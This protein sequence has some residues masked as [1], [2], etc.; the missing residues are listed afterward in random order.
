[1]KL[2][3]NQP[4]SQSRQYKNLGILT[5]AIA[6]ALT[7]VAEQAQAAQVVANGTSETASGTYDTGTTT[8]TAGYGIYTLNNG[9]VTSTGTVNIVTGGS[10][11]RGVYVGTGG[12][13]TLDH[14]TTITQTGTSSRG[15]EVS[16]TTSLFISNGALHINSTSS[17]SYG[18]Y[19]SQ[20]TA[21]MNGGGSI[22]SYYY[23]LYAANAANVT[24]KD[25]TIETIG[26][27]AAAYI[28]SGSTVDLTNV[29]LINTGSSNTVQLSGAGSKLIMNGGS[30]TTKL[31]TTAGAALAVEQGAEFDLTG[32]AINTSTDSGEGIAVST[33]AFG[34]IRDSS[35]TTSGGSDVVGDAGAGAVGVRA[36]NG[37]LATVINTDIITSGTGSDGIESRD[38]GSQVT[39]VGG[40]V[41][42][43]ADGTMGVSARTGGIVQIGNGTLVT[44]SGQD[45]HA[46]YSSTAG[47][48]IV[49]DNTSIVTTGSNAHA[50][51]AESGGQIQL[52]QSNGQLTSTQGNSLYAEGGQITVVLDGS[53]VQ[54]SGILID[55][56]ADASNQAG[57]VDLT[58]SNLTMGGDIQ[59]DATSVA[60]LNLRSAAWSGKATNGTAFDLDGGST[61]NMTASSDVASLNH[62]GV[63]RYA[64]PVGRNFNTL[65]VHNQYTGNNGTVVL[66]TELGAD[67]SPTDRLVVE[68]NTAGQT[69]LQVV[70]AN[71]AG[72]LTAADGIELVSVAGQ[73]DGSF[74]LGNRVVA[75][76]YEYSL[77]QGGVGA[78]SDNGNWYLRSTGQVRSETGVYLRNMA[79]A[80]TMFVH[81]LHDRL[82]EPQFTDKYREGEQ[83]PA[84]WVRI[85]GNQTDSRA[86]NG[87][88]DLD[89]DTY[90]VHLGGDLARWSSNGNDRM[91]FGLMGAYGRS[92]INA[93]TRQLYTNSGFSGTASGKVDGYSV[94]A[95]F[96]WYGNENKPTGP[97]I[98][99]WGQYNW[100]N[101]E[102]KGSGLAKESYD[103]SGW[104]VS[105]EGGYAFIAIDG[106]TRQWMIEPQVQIAFNSYSADDHREING[107]WV[108]NGD[109][110]SMIARVGARFYSRDKLN[111]NAIQPFVEANWWYS[112]QQNS[113]SFNG[114]A[115]SDDTPQN[116]YELKVGL[117]GEI[118]DGW[119][120]W[121]HVNGRW[122]NNG[123]SSYGGMV[124]VKYNF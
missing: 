59:A 40:S 24:A 92:D 34:T 106:Q 111:E 94:G 88:I 110:D 76:V 116:T 4:Y 22:T 10:S 118:A 101:N 12:Q 43:A 8:G 85:S 119:Q 30:V 77:Y 39:M 97:Y 81:T 67:A 41:Q 66:N 70:N 89:T 55:A 42:V 48:S 57:T 113:L 74:R 84:V 69:V 16:G 96:T 35:I 71:G 122:G 38:A 75:G 51:V 52:N 5:S 124:G 9:V 123:Y 65:T 3:A 18:V 79:A 23:G 2:R 58:A 61:W 46:L 73:S 14:D 32:I 53:T 15:V 68:G 90:V 13:V 99:L 27:T 19:V 21:E 72:A 63:I 50:V 31:N 114:V 121:G 54:N 87:Q 45:S 112:D 44:T 120:V 6:I 91:H 64:S 115:L 105:A 7:T 20:G 109:E 104:T 83:A 93:D 56:R 29:A 28:V 98:D 36:Y 60:N 1:M 26:T 86:A 49:A 33:G 37:G 100:F 82:G 25:M 103:S 95:Y 47:S 108:S 107:T 78:N 80:S 102:V 62:A 11:V 17:S 117:Q